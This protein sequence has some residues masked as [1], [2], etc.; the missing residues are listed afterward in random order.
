MVVINL[1]GGPGSGKSTTAAGLFFKMKLDKNIRSV[2][3]V[4]EFAKE[5]IYAGRTKELNDNQLYVTAEQYG[6]IQRLRDQVDYII[7]DSP[8]IQGLMYIPDNYFTS[9]PSLLK[10]IYNSFDNFN[11]FINRVKEYKTYGRDRTEEESDLISQNVLNFL[12]E[13]SISYVRVDGDT[14][15]PDIIK[16]LVS[17]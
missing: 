11:I 7:T 10:E 3:L 16:R 13:N 15:A 14:N 8:L 4:T 9:F 6:R 2:E 12:D 5:L 1:F 17:I